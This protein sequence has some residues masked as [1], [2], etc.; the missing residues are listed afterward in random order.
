MWD[1]LFVSAPWFDVSNCEKLRI[2]IIFNFKCALKIN[3]IG[4]L[5]TS[6]TNKNYYI[7]FD[8]KFNWFDANYACTQMNMN[9]LEIKSESKSHEINMVLKNVEKQ[10]NIGNL[11]IGGIWTLYPSRNLVWL[12]T[13]EKFSYTNWIDYNPD[14]NRNDEFCV[15][16]IKRENWKWNDIDCTNRLGFVCEYSKEMEI[17]KKLEYEPQFKEEELNALDDLE[18]TECNNL[19]KEIIDL[20]DNENELL[21][22][23]QNLTEQNK[24]IE[25]DLK[26]EIQK[27]QN[28][29]KQLKEQETETRN[30]HEVKLQVEITKQQI[31]QKELENLQKQLQKFKVSDLEKHLHIAQLLN[32]PQNENQLNDTNGPNNIYVYSPYFIFLNS[33]NNSTNI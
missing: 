29:I 33:V 31:L 21:L 17:P 14:F 13:G 27:L 12:Y 11:W 4:Q 16:L 15:E 1:C 23:L 9:L 26:M 18:E 30:Q 2:V 6:F 28:E 10:T 7:D 5:Y 19:Q 3:A 25:K 24:Q 20:K 32:Q 22:Q 8:Q